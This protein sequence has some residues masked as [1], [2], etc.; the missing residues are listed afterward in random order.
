MT[1][2]FVYYLLKIPRL[3]R[4]YGFIVKYS[5]CHGDQD[6]RIVTGYQAKAKKEESMK[7]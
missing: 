3:M 2:F 1:R 5:G 4:T 7:I 6:P